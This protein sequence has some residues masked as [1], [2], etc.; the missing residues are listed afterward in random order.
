MKNKLLG[1]MLC[2]MIGGSVVVTS[3]VAGATQ[4]KPLNNNT[5]KTSLLDQEKKRQALELFENCKAKCRWLCND[6]KY[7]QSKYS[8][9][10]NFGQLLGKCRCDRGKKY[11]IIQFFNRE[12]DCNEGLSAP[13]N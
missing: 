9:Y 6:R 3:A 10:L 1:L 8:E 13:I 12:K 2:A 5:E 7:N 4:G 11:E